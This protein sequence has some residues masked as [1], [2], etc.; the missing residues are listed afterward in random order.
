[1]EFV[2]DTYQGYINLSLK[3]DEL[4]ESQ[5]FYNDSLR[6]FCKTVTLQPEAAGCFKLPGS[7]TRTIHI[8]NIRVTNLGMIPQTSKWR[9]EV[10]GGCIDQVHCS[11]MPSLRKL[12]GVTDPSVIPFHI[13]S[14]EHMFLPSTE[15]HEQ[16]ILFTNCTAHTDITITCDVY[17]T[18]DCVKSSIEHEY[19]LRH[20]EAVY[21]ALDIQDDLKRRIQPF[22]SYEPK[23]ILDHQ[24]YT[25]FIV[26]CER[27]VYDAVK[28]SNN[29]NKIWFNFPT[30]HLFIKSPK[31]LTGLALEFNGMNL[32]MCDT[33]LNDD[34]YTI[35]LTEERELIST[36]N[37]GINFS[38]IDR[39]VLHYDVVDFEGPFEFEMW[40]VH[41]N[42]CMSLSGLMGVRF[43]T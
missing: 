30:S 22:L 6:L 5:K 33:E 4:K 1:M 15:Y 32:I 41:A 29:V 39:V 24:A 37:H 31:R 28:A 40:S 14:A 34:V 26:Q 27:G 21:P 18:V 8:R 42:V 2:R 10:G 13:T 7:P 9:L 38:R 43:A 25:F 20:L 17:D 16:K 11:A 23:L 12:Y 35:H 3:S 19:L 36:T